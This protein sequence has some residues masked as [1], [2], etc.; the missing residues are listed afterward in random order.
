M[1]T[2]PVVAQVEADTTCILVT[3]S[4]S[5]PTWLAGIRKVI[6]D[7]GL[8]S[9]VRATADVD[10]ALQYSSRNWTV[11][12]P[13]FDS[14]GDPAID[15]NRARDISRALSRAADAGGRVNVIDAST[16]GRADS[17]ALTPEAIMD[18]QAF[19]PD[20]QL[21]AGLPPALG[22]YRRGHPAPGD[23]A[24]WPLDFLHFSNDVVRNGA[25][26]PTVDISGYVRI[27]AWGPHIFLPR[28]RW[29]VTLR[30]E[31]DAAASREH[32]A[33]DWGS[34]SSHTRLTARPGT[35]GIHEAVLDHVWERAEV[36]E[37]RVS[38]DRA[39]FSGQLTLLGMTVE[40][41]E[42]E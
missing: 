39:A 33:F 42:D 11:F 3:P 16:L 15:G 12:L 9:S 10:E 37:L 1:Q 5:T 20:P 22:I 32:L 2:H 40:R 41:L 25:G 35:P 31:V 34:L 38:L 7:A 24:D 8:E 17:V 23:K 6:S 13:T 30:I 28:G 4:P 26:L 14:Q 19:A 36:A 27:F 29:R 21:K 18:R